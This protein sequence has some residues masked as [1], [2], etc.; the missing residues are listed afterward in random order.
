MNCEECKNLITV[1]VFGKLTS[2]EKT[3]LEEHL[4]ACPGCSRIY[5]KSV[6]LSSLSEGKD[7]IPLP[8]K[9][10]SWQIIRAKT[11]PKRGRWKDVFSYKKL[12]FVT[13]AVLAV[14][15][16]GFLAGKL[17]FFQP[18]APGQP[19]SFARQGY[20]M[21]VERYAENLE[22]ILVSFMNRTDAQKQDQISDLEK[23]V[24][25]DM[26]L[27]TKL[28]KYLVAERGDLYLQQLLEDLELILVGIS[29]LRPQDQDSAV[30]LAR[31]I[32]D[33]EL[34]F[35]VKTLLTSKTTI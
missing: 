34:K 3:L 5:E 20:E 12:A 33:N 11:L 23:K 29:N 4:R 26:L 35:K 7:D 22:L 30:Q 19:E 14:F 18:P 10:K 2:S 1:S 9:E 8:N 24:I 31:I 16:L 28:L 21:P 17:F 27:Q 13:S 6:Q 25:E 15:I 32:R